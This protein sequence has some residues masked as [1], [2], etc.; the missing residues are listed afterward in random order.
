MESSTRLTHESVGSDSVT[1]RAPACITLSDDTEHWDECSTKQ[2]LP[3][4]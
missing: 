1:S 3:S 4:M 2:T